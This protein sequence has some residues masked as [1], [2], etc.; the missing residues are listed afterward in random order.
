M[1]IRTSYVSNSSS[2]SYVICRDMT[3][4]G[5]GCYKLRPDMYAAVAKSLGVS[6]APDKDW[7]VTRFLTYADDRNGN[8]DKLISG[9]HY[10][11]MDG[12]MSGNPYMND[13]GDCWGVEVTP[14]IWMYDTDIG[15]RVVTRTE[16][17]KLLPKRCKFLYQVESDGC[18]KLIPQQ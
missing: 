14:G 3:D 18:I 8:Y 11:Y 10:V 13:D 6:L 7:Y 17:L 16:L 12:E 4:D 9:E 5:I 1:K 2:S 15:D